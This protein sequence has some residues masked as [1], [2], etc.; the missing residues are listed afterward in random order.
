MITSEEVRKRFDGYADRFVARKK[1]LPFK[2]GFD[3]DFIMRYFSQQ[4]KVNELLNIYKKF[5]ILKVID[6]LSD[7]DIKRLDELES[8]LNDNK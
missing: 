2:D 3:Y 8:E 4:E 7:E 1:Y 5:P 6:E